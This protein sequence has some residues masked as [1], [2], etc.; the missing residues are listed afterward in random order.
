MVTELL[1]QESGTGPASRSFIRDGVAGNYDV[2]NQMVRVIRH[3]VDT[4]K[5][6]ESFSKQL[7]IGAGENGYSDADKILTT[8]YDYVKRTITYTPDIAGRIESIKSARATLRDTYGDCDDQAVLNASILGCLGY[9]STYIAMARYDKTDTSFSHVYTV[10]YSS[11][12]RY[13]LDTTLPNGKLNDEVKPIEIKEIPIFGDVPGYDGISG[14]FNN[15]KYYGSQFGKAVISFA[16]TVA[17]TLPLGFLAGNA[18]AHGAQMIG[19]VT[20]QKL[21]FNAAASRIN[22]QLNIIIQDLLKS[23]IALDLAQSNAVQEVAQLAT[24]DHTDLADSDYQTIRQSVQDKVTF[25]KN[26]ETYAKANNIPVVYLNAHLMLASGILLT[27]GVGYLFY[28]ELKG[29]R[30]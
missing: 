23:R 6:L 14:I 5:P 15:A 8:V 20:H 4:D 19:N 2:V 9:D 11:G 3:S 18:F 29:R 22:K 1:T 21:S 17:D 7:I 30:N 24:I 25:I 13:V 10:C 26:F 27:G 16:P 28:K 12:K